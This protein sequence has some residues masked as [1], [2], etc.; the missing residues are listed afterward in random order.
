[1]RVP[2]ALL[3]LLDG[4]DVQVGAIDVASEEIESPDEVAAVIAEATKYLPKESIIAGTNCG[5]APMRLDIA[6]G[7][8]EALGKGAALARK[9]FA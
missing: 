6:L 9:R 3:K 8:L 2:I 4:K 7:K 5:M 1:S